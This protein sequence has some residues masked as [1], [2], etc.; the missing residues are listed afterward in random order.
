MRSLAAV[1][2]VATLITMGVAMPTHAIVSLHNYGLFFSWLTMSFIVTVCGFPLLFLSILC[3]G[4]VWSTSVKA[5]KHPETDQDADRARSIFDSINKIAAGM[6]LLA[7]FGI[8]QA[9]GALE[10]LDRF[11]QLRQA[12][13]ADLVRTLLSA[14][15]EYQQWLR[16]FRQKNQNVQPQQIASASFAYWSVQRRQPF[17]V[18]APGLAGINHIS[19]ATIANG[20]QPGYTATVD[21]QDGRRN[22]RATVGIELLDGTDQRSKVFEFAVQQGVRPSADEKFDDVFFRLQ[23]ELISKESEIPGSGLSFSAGQIIWI[24]V[25][26]VVAGMILTRELIIK[27]LISGLWA[28]NEPWLLFDAVTA[29]GKLLAI[30][31]KVFLFIVPYY[32]CMVAVRFAGMQLRVWRPTS[33]ISYDLTLYCVIVFLVSS[34]TYLSLSSVNRVFEIGNLREFAANPFATHSRGC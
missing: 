16:D 31:A 12:M 25:A 34:I 11:V 22:W 33:A 7:V 17:D 18:S 4:Y 20:P 8:L 3:L 32:F 6:G 29:T 23:Q 1:Q 27:L 30:V 2:L 28:A 19:I 24:S 10:R 14:D 5:T 21:M 15:T 13:S 26:I 9:F